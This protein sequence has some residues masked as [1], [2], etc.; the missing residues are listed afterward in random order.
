M[1]HR[2]ARLGAAGRLAQGGQLALPRGDELA[3]RAAGPGSVR[4][5]N[6]GVARGHYEMWL[7]PKIPVSP[8]PTWCAL[9]S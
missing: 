5:A 2:R 1:G 8:T 4:E 9:L 6:P 3:T 7:R